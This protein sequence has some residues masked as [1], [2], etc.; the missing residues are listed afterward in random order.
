MLAAESQSLQVNS[1]HHHLKEEDLGDLCEALDEVCS[2]Y[3]QFGLRIGL[4]LH[5]IERIEVQYNDVHDRLLYVLS[6]RLNKEKPFTWND[7]DVALRSQ[8]VGKSKLAD[9][10]WRERFFPND[11]Q[12]KQLKDK[13]CVQKRDDCQ[14]D[15]QVEKGHEYDYNEKGRNDEGK[16]ES[17]RSSDIDDSTA[18]YTVSEEQKKE[19]RKVFQCFFW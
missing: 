16:H 4:V 1:P 9:S 5:E 19:L 11:H 15:S 2:K 3:K 10:L 17:S 13:S 6:V 18:A 7:I 12:K 8:C 14:G